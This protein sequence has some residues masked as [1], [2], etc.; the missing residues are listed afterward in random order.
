M[1]SESYRGYFIISRATKEDLNANAWAPR[2]WVPQVTIFWNV[3]DRQRWHTIKPALV[4]PD[5]SQAESEGLFLAKLWVD[6]KCV[7]G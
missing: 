4:F 5:E 2:G 7:T 1:A 6:Q 3:E